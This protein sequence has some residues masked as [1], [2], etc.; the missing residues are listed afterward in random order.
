MSRLPVALARRPLVAARRDLGDRLLD[1]PLVVL[2]IELAADDA[3]GELGGKAAR[4]SVE[5]AG[6]L[7]RRD[8]DLALGALDHLVAL[9]LGLFLDLALDRLGV[10][11]PLVDDGGRLGPRP[12]Q[13]LPVLAQPVLRLRPIPPRGLERVA[14]VGLPRL[15][16]GEQRPP[17]VLAEHH[18]HQHEDD[19][20]PQRVADV[21]GKDVAAAALRVGGRGFGGE[22]RG[23]GEQPGRRRGRESQQAGHYFETR[24]SMTSPNSATPSISAAVMIIALLIGPTDSGWRAIDSVA[25][26]PIRP[27]PRPAPSLRAPS[28]VRPVPCS[29][30]AP[31]DGEP[32]AWPGVAAA[33]I[34]KQPPTIDIRAN[35]AALL[36]IGK[37]PFVGSIA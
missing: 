16:A 28:V 36:L 3:G 17:G 6:G 24:K 25:L 19:D 7:H 33:N 5:L 23:G 4:Q 20:R 11:A 10:A 8:L 31:A 14:D 30:T 22:G 13:L 34:R 18:H 12:G 37:D 9:V 35:F 26:P 1:Q 21:A 32:W 27:M 15:Q 2:G 29:S